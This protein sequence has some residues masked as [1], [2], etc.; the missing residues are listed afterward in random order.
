MRAIVLPGM[1]GTGLLLEDFVSALSPAFDAEA[2]AYPSQGDNDYDTLTEHV[3]ARLPRGTRHLLVAESF[4]GQ[5]AIR[6]AARH[7]DG[8]AGLVLC[9]TF[10]R[11]PGSA[12]PRP[13]ARFASRMP[14]RWLPR[15]LLHAAMMGRWSTRA[16]RR[17]TEDALAQVDDDVLRARWNAVMRVNDVPLLASIRIPVLYLRA[18]EDRVV[19]SA[20]RQAIADALPSMTTAM[21]EGPHF[22]LQLRAAECAD[23]IRAWCDRWP[24]R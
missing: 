17:R 5:I 16:W 3:F 11:T 2:I 10:A 6:I 21:V 4:S 20:S 15:P 7:P 22:L 12:L 19:S 13:L 1:D 9:A 23:A 8:L 14:V 24:Q 18:S